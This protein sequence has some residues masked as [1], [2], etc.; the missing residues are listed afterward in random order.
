M[1][2]LQ[3]RAMPRQIVSAARSR[4]DITEVM[5]NDPSKR[6]SGGAGIQLPGP[7]FPHGVGSC[8]LGF[9]RGDELSARENRSGQRGLFTGTVPVLALGVL[10][11]VLSA[12]SS[13]CLARPCLRMG[14][15]TGIG[16]LFAPADAG[17][18][19]FPPLQGAPRTTGCHPQF[20]PHRGIG[21]DTPTVGKVSV[22]RWYNKFNTI[23][24]VFFVA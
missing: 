4:T 17:T 20:H 24:N 3:R 21:S 16:G 2:L 9:L 18:H 11:K 10:P 19:V 5:G 13:C 14:L 12:T 8:T 1:I 7:G 22:D 23:D 15:R 6:Q